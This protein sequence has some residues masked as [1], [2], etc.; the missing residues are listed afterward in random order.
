MDKNELYR[1]LEWFEN[2]GLTELAVE[3]GSGWKAAMK[4]EA[5]GRPGKTE[6]TPPASPLP[7]SSAS[8]PHPESDEVPTGEIIT[9]PMVGVFY[10]SPAA[11]A[12][13][14]VETGSRINPGDP[15]CILE[16]MKVMN[17]LEAEF[18]GEIIEVLAENGTL[19]EF[20]TPLF[21]IRRDDQVSA[22]R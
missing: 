22:D 19:V 1:L 4:K 17:T 2:S 18:G 20:G 6:P 9:S 12:P 14:F 8:S 7:P 5:A 3:D 11:D 21:R 16:A 13:P 10:R 15:L